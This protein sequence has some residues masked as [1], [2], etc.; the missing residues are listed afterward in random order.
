[1]TYVTNSLTSKIKNKTR[2]IKQHLTPLLQNKESDVEFYLVDAFEI[3]HFM[4]LCRALLKSGVRAEIVAEPP[5]INTGGEW[6]NYQTAIKIMK[7]EGFP[8]CTKANSDAAVAITTQFYKN[9]AN[10]NGL[11][12]MFNYGVSLIPQADFRTRCDVISPFDFI[13]VHGSYSANIVTRY[14]PEGHAVIMSYPKLLPLLESPP[15]KDSV[16]QELGIKTMK[17]ILV[18]YPTWDDYSSIRIFADAL[19]KLRDSYYIVSKPHHCTARRLGNPDDIDILH[20]ISDLV[21]DAN[22][23]LLNMSTIGDISVCDL[24]SGI[25]TELPFMNNDM[26]LLLLQVNVDDSDILPEADKF[27]IR[28]RRPEELSSAV[29][30][31]HGGDAGDPYIHSRKTITDRFYMPDI[32]Q[33]LQNATDAIVRMLETSDGVGREKRN[34]KTSPNDGG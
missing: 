20:R 24:K 27:A 13:F 14:L 16:M 17:P 29:Y 30:S 32:R 28:I 18:Y 9:L 25:T 15:H 8:Y 3:F 26:K 34:R 10:Y 2:K 12:C 1:M 31:L 19:E 23:S 5:W 21:V 6:F 22:Y 7:R 11:K 4:P 33:G